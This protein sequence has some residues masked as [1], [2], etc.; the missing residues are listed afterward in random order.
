MKRDERL[1]RYQCPKCKKIKYQNNWIEA[2]YHFINRLLVLGFI[3]AE[4]LC[5]KC[6]GED[7]DD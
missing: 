3:F 5:D 2:D 6:E 7:D 1:V 4:K